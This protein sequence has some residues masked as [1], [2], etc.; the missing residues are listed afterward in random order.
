MISKRHVPCL[1]LHPSGPFQ[2]LRIKTKSPVWIKCCMDRTCLFFSFLSNFVSLS[3]VGPR[4]PFQ[5]LKYALSPFTT[6]LCTCS[7]LPRMAL[8]LLS[9]LIYS[10]LPSNLTSSTSHLVMASDNP[11]K[12]GCLLNYGLHRSSLLSSGPPQVCQYLLMC[13]LINVGHSHFSCAT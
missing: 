11:P 9:P 13:G 3:L 1:A 5:F 12:P 8:F 10:W 6:A 2:A 7:A 4:F